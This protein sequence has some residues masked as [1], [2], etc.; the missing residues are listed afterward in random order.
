[1]KKFALFLVLWLGWQSTA[2]AGDKEQ[3]VS[4]V[5]AVSAAIANGE[6]VG[7]LAVTPDLS[8][9]TSAALKK[10]RKCRGSATDDST[11]TDVT[12]TYVCGSVRM[13]RSSINIPDATAIDMHFENGTMTVLSIREVKATSVVADEL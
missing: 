8:E 12:L 9:E 10:L 4:A 6:D 5:K 1:V 3:V 11:L 2:M 13:G 7:A